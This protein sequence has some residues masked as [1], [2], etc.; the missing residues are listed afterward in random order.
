MKVVLKQSVAVNV[1]QSFTLKMPEEAEIVRVGVD[2]NN[3]NLLS[4][5]YITEPGKQPTVDRYFTTVATGESTAAIHYVGT[6]I[7]DVHYVFHVWEW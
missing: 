5:W 7:A 4:L 6:F 2:P 3:S 1:A